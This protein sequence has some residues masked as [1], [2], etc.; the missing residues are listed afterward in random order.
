MSKPPHIQ[1]GALPEGVSGCGNRQ[2]ERTWQYKESQPPL[3]QLLAEFT[4]E[5]SHYGS[6]S[7]ISAISPGANWQR[8]TSSSTS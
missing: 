5:P 6:L 2:V 4:E 8:G 3:G 1:R 7:R